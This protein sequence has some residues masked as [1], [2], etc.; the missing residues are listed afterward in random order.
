[1]KMTFKTIGEEGKALRREVK[2]YHEEGKRVNPPMSPEDL[3]EATKTVGRQFGDVSSKILGSADSLED[4]ADALGATADVTEILKVLSPDFE[5][6][7]RVLGRIDRAADGGLDS[8]LKEIGQ[9]KYQAGIE[10]KAE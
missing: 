1:M 6:C 9:V 7:K 8:T 10:N 5:A 4:F 2:Q 3:K